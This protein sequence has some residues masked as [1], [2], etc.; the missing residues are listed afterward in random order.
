M[1]YFSKY[2]LSHVIFPLTLLCYNVLMNNFMGNMILN[3]R[4]SF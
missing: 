4:L 3:S 1:H 2:Y